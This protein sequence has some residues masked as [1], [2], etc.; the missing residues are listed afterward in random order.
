MEILLGFAKLDHFLT[1]TEEELSKMMQLFVSQTANMCLIIFIANLN[2]D[3]ID[4]V[5]SIHDSVP[6]TRYF[7]QGL[8][9]DFTRFWYIKVGMAIMVLKTINILWPQILSLVFMVPVC[10]LRRVLC[11]HKAVI[12]LEMNRYYEGISINLWDRYACSLANLF[13]AFTFSS[14]IPILLP[15]HALYLITQYWIDKALCNPPTTWNSP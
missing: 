12:Q 1:N 13:F 7:F 9:P 5:R 10:A 11:A 15:L 2:L 6:W 4:F 14:G 8:H 3:G